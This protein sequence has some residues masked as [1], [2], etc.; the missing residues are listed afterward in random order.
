MPADLVADT[1][2][3]RP[4]PLRVGI[5]RLLAELG[6]PVTRVAD[7]VGVRMPSPG[8][9]QEL[10]IATGVPV[11]SVQRTAFDGS[12]APVL[13][14]SALLPGDRHELRYDVVVDAEGDSGPADG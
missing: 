1:E 11:L 6:H 7:E 10:Q 8:E 4:E 2:L 9:A 12:D 5:A 3:G 13:T 14:V